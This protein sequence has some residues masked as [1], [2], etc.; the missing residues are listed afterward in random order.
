MTLSVQ[1][2]A[3]AGEAGGRPRWAATPTRADPITLVCAVCVCRRR[4]LTR[5]CFGRP[6]C[7][8][9]L[10]GVGVR[11][12]KIESSSRS[13]AGSANGWG[14][15]RGALRRKLGLPPRSVSANVRTNFRRRIEA[16]TFLGV[17]FPSEPPS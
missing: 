2:G 12:S 4:Y 10:F 1:A 13:G 11:R 6:D 17:C 7:F 16:S 8:G 14:W 3:R 15:G 5:S 9:V